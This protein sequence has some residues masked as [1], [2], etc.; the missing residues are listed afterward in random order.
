MSDNIEFILQTYD[1]WK[2]GKCNSSF[3]SN[4]VIWTF[5]SNVVGDNIIIHLADGSNRNRFIIQ[6]RGILLHFLKEYFSKMS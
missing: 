2:V 1:E 4:N 6:N 5:S 3:T